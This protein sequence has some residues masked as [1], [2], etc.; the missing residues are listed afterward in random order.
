MILAI[1]P[2]LKP[3][4]AILDPDVLVPRGPLMQERSLPRIIWTGTRLPP[5]TYHVTAV[6][7]EAQ[8]SD[9]VFSR[10]PKNRVSVDS[11]L[12]LAFTAGTQCATAS[13]A[14]AAYPY[15]IL[16]TAW[17]AAIGPRNTSAQVVYNRIAA[18]LTQEE[19][20][21]VTAHRKIDDILAAI[22][23]GWAHYLGA[24]KQRIKF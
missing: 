19:S 4:Y 3:G 20:E 22:G 5:T 23:I 10:D 21:L 7:V 14:F 16:P 24:S 13:F 15:T 8:W 1:D 17:H 9:R 11:L 12:S 6:V 18:A 2:G